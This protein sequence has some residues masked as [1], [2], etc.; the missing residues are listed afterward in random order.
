MAKRLICLLCL[1]FASLLALASPL[2]EAIADLDGG[3]YEQAAGKLKPLAEAGDP[4][5]QHRLSI[6]Y[7]YGH[8]VPEDE[9]TALSWATRSAKAGNVDAMFFAGNI[10]VFGDKIPSEAEDPDV[11][12]AKWFHEAASRG[13]PEAE[14][15]LGLLFLAG[16]GVIQSQEE[17]MKWIGRA[18]EHG[19][20]GARNF[21]GTGGH[22]GAQ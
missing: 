20:V 15:S 21:I 1:S 2:D 9:K 16:K 8:G 11:E 6:L 12:A 3:R 4:V 14:Y 5:A 18:A 13:H 17:A 19:H 10:Y 7:F 22:G